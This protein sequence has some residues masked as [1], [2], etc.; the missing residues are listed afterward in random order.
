MFATQI[1]SA[2][3]EILREA[4]MIGNNGCL[5]SFQGGFDMLSKEKQKRFL[6][7]Q[8]RDCRC[9]EVPCEESVLR[10]ITGANS[11]PTQGE[12]FIGEVYEH[13]SRIN[14]ACLSNTFS[15]FTSEGN[16]IIYAGRDIEEGEELGRDYMLGIAPDHETVLFRREILQKVYGFHCICDACV[17]RFDSASRDFYS[18]ESKKK[19]VEL[20]SNS[21]Y[22][23]QLLGKHTEEEIASW[24]RVE[25]WMESIPE[26]VGSLSFLEPL[27]T[28]C[29]DHGVAGSFTN[30]PAQI[31]IGLSGVL[32]SPLR[33]YFEQNNPLDLSEDTLLAAELGYTP[34][35]LIACENSYSFGLR[36]R[37]SVPH[38]PMHPSDRRS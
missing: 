27:L 25:D 9:F 32:K 8:R 17:N 15:T 19:R 38:H 1:I 36:A 29:I 10:K 30:D 7:L 2:G 3:S 34:I 22:T 31:P 24:K 37:S 23:T 21:R 12:R 13:S 14:H 4:P 18:P 16:V 20:S 11:F 28:S 33:N 6:T 5:I 26:Q 35:T